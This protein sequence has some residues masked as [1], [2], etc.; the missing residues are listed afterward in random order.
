M[1]KRQP[2]ECTALVLQGG[3]ALGSY[4]AGVYEA[5]AE[6]G[7]EPGWVA[8]ISIGA[9]N[10]AIIAGNAPKD[11]VAKLRQFWETVTA[12]PFLDWAGM[13][14]TMTPQGIMAR[15]FF[16]Q[17]SACISLTAGANDFF[18]PRN[19]PP[20]FQPDGSKGATS[21]YD[22]S[23]L[24]GTLE[25]L[26]DFDRI[27]HDGM[28]LS[29]GTVNVRTGNFAYFDTTKDVLCADHILASCSLPPGFGATEIDGEFYWDGGMVSNTPLQWVV[30][31][32]TRKD[33]LV[34]QIDLWPAEG[35][36]PRN[37]TDVATRQKDIQYSSRTR[38]A[39][40]QFKRM[41]TMRNALA[42]LIEDLPA[43]MRDHTSL[44]V[45]KCVADHKVYNIVHLIYRS[46]Q[47]E[48]NSKDYDF[49]RLAMNEHW[50][51]GMKDARITLN[52]PEI[53]NR[54]TIQEGV[55]TFDFLDESPE[56]AAKQA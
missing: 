18:Q 55:L 50:Q 43:A 39:T 44:D 34:F 12:N 31:G 48:I 23:K 10:A 32:E 54:P 56:K 29:V 53:F 35:N 36:L 45:L 2:F 11:R 17:M 27:N 4:Q 41:Q 16:N 26:V 6:A 47:Y 42:S 7:V 8:G 38:A 46:R 40:D 49:S 1:P 52:H 20:Y 3:G 28:R 22:T 13:M 5:M 51:S 25:R 33:T 15:S 14:D 24:K 19:P 30:D 37:L 21:F 9:I